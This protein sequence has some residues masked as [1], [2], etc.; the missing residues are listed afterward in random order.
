MLS[1]YRA[2]LNVVLST[3]TIFTN[4]IDPQDSEPSDDPICSGKIV[5]N[6]P[7]AKRCN[8]IKVVLTALSDLGGVGFRL[9][10]SIT[11]RKELLIDLNNQVLDAGKHE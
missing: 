7:K 5:L 2:S 9:Q 3:S 10:S 11:L 8:R 6:L 1:R 4:P